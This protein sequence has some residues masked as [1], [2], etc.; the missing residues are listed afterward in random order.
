MTETVTTAYRVLDEAA[1]RALL[2]GVPHVAAVLG[3]TPAAWSVCEVGDGNLNQVFLVKGPAGGVCAKQALPY[4]RAAG[5]SWPLK[6]I[7][8]FY[9][10][11]CMMAHGPH[12]AGHAPDVYHFEPALYLIVM[13]L[14]QPHIIMRRGMIAGTRYPCFAAHIGDYMAR[15][16]FFTSDLALRAAEKKAQM[17]IFCG[18]TELCKITEDLIFTDPYTACDRNRWTSPQLDGIA[19]AFRG[20]AAL[21]AAVSEL[22]LRFMADAQALLHGDLHTGSVMVTETDTR[23]I[24]PEFAFYGPM[25]FDVGAVIGN[26]LINY[27]AQDGHATAD[28]PR[29]AYQA[30]VLQTV[31]DVWTGFAAKFAALWETDRTGGAY[32]RALFEDAGDRDALRAARRA[33]MAALYRD[34]LR[35]GAAKMIRRILGFAHNIDLDW[36]ADADMRALCETRCLRLARA[37]LVE[38]QRFGSIDVLTDAAVRTRS[39]I[40]SLT[41]T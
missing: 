26:L 10:Y 36:I 21:K 8:A 1:L 38:P 24:D 25:G 20:D 3:G 29:D 40:T 11:C 23:V 13:E 34:T 28:D 33:Y 31:R 6:P 18:N 35:F 19:A 30:W 32:P 27:F 16:L 4:V 12:A 5:E 17:T 37:M 39:T 14:L 2:A 41:G 9:E 7:R 22:K 15:T